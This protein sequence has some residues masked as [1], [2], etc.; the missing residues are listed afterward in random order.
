MAPKIVSLL[1]IRQELEM[2]EDGI[3]FS[4]IQRSR[5][6]ANK[7]MYTPEKNSQFS[8][9]FFDCFLFEQESFHSRFGRYLDRTE[10]PFFEGLPHC[11]VK[12]RA[13]DCALAEGIEINVNGRIKRTYL[14]QLAFFCA[15]GDEEGDYGSSAEYDVRC[16]QELSRRIHYGMV[17][18]ESK[19]HDD[20][21]GYGELV[22]V[23]DRPGVVAKLRDIKVEE[24]ILA[25]LK[26]KGIRYGFNPGLISNFYKDHVIPMT[27]DVEV[28][29]LFRRAKN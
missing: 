10:H 25:R 27:I 11:I 3:M 8:R 12:R 23:G 15:E 26:D 4:L 28:D 2:M 16:L 5:R 7:G 9:S 18:A 20:P 6:K 21:A 17:V 13:R 29:Y 19:Y 14:D 24:K 1:E 22:K